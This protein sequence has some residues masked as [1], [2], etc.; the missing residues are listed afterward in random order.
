L[1]PFNSEAYLQRGRAYDRIRQPQK[2]I[3]DFSAALALMPPQYESPAEALL[4]VECNNLAWHYVAVPPRKRD[5]HKALP[6][7]QRA[8][9]LIPQDWIFWNTLGVVYYRL[10]RYE[11]A[12]EALERSSRESKREDAA[13]NL[14]FLAMCHARRGDD[15]KAKD[16][17]DR[18]LHWVQE[19]E[20]KLAAAEKQEL[21]DFRAEAAAV[22]SQAKP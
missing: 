6:L 7:A 1:N 12:I 19:R 4:P 17:Y 16:C 8:V 5:P 15:A 2:A 22:R 9:T 13:Y 3:A 20:Y 21:D 18:A 10:A 11:E 14:F